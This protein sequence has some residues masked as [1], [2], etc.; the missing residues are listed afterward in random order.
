IM[1]EAIVHNKH[2]L[3]PCIT[4]LEGEYGQTDIAIGVPVVLGKNGVEKIVELDF[5]D[6]E[7]QDFNAS[8]QAIKGLIKEI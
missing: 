3:L 1:V 4:M 5:T 8:A 7:Q 2:R 6:K